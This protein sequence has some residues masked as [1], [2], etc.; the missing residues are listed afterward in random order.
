MGWD[1]FPGDMCFGS[2][3]EGSVR[4]THPGIGNPGTP[5]ALGLSS[6]FCTALGG[7]L[8]TL[9]RLRFRVSPLLPPLTQGKHLWED[10]GPGIWGHLTLLCPVVASGEAQEVRQGSKAI[11]PC[12]MEVEGAGGRGQ[13]QTSPV[14]IPE[15][16]G[17]LV[18][19]S[20]AFV[21]WMMLG[22]LFNSL[23]LSLL[24]WKMGGRIPTSL[25]E[26]GLRSGMEKRCVQ[27]LQGRALP[28]LGSLS[29]ATGPQG[30][31]S[32]SP[33]SVPETWL[34]STLGGHS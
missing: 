17:W 34:G 13:G 31:R 6:L 7:S 25:R 33:F 21:D 23:S 4:C 12:L 3:I 8:S 14:G 28:S 9:P 19:P 11:L 18:R 27:Q 26:T 1:P 29:P 20:F 5:W 32:L 15:T 2:A 30:A 22:N 24:K 16:G 10:M